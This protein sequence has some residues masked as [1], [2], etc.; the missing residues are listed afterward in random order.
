MR[1]LVLALAILRPRALPTPHPT[2]HLSPADVVGIVLHAL[3]H[4]DVPRADAGIATTFEFASPANRTQ[5]GP[6][7]RFTVLVKNSVYRPMIGFRSARRDPVDVSGD[8]ARQRVT[9][10][11]SNGTQAV[12]IFLLSRQHDAPYENC[13]MTDGVLRE[14]PPPLAPGQTAT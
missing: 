11:A 13:W 6:L 4:N 10:A 3:Q 2:P 9:I 12:Y 8:Y 1:A 7:E 14:A 5:T